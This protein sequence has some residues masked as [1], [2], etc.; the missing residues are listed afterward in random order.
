MCV[1]HVQE[2]KPMAKLMNITN[3]YYYFY[4]GFTG[5]DSRVNLRCESE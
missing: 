4:F 5:A 2:K 3:G 1:E